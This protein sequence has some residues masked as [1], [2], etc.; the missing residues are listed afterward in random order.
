MSDADPGQ[1]MVEWMVA[2]PPAE[3]AVEL[4]V[5]FGPE[6]QPHSL[7]LELNG[8]EEW[9]FRSY[10]KRTGMILRAR[11]VKEPILE[12]LQLLEH[13]ELIYV[14]TDTDRYWRATRLG[15]SILA[16]GKDAVRQRI[17]DRTGL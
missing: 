12:A 14:F 3:L 2:A 13:S 4:L 7:G 15:L 17:K 6:G 10:P 9:M 11:P 8:L 16:A 5:A 1:P